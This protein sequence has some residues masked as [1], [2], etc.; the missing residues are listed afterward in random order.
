[1]Q[2]ALAQELADIVL[3]IHVIPRASSSSDEK[4]NA[5]TSLDFLQGFFDAMVREWSG[6]DKWR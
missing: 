3:N 1:M 4:D 2:Q 5:D 6:L